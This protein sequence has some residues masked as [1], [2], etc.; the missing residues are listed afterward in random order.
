MRLVSGVVRPWDVRFLGLRPAREN[1]V[2]YWGHPDI[3]D[4]LNSAMI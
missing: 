3:A 2:G 1:A 4:R